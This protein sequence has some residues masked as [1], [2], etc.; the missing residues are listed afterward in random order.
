VRTFV[1]HTLQTKVTGYWS[2]S[3]PNK[4]VFN[5]RWNCWRVRWDCCR[6]D[7][8]L[9]H[10]HGPATGNARSRQQG[11]AVGQYV[12]SARSTW[13]STLPASRTQHPPGLLQQQELAKAVLLAVIWL[14]VLIHQVERLLCQH[15]ALSIAWR[16]DG[17]QKSGTSSSRRMTCAATDH[18]SFV[19]RRQRH[20]RPW[21]HSL[22]VLPPVVLLGKKIPGHIYGKKRGKLYG[23]KNCIVPPYILYA[24]HRWGCLIM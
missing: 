16:R 20:K 6:L 19:G 22:N 17:A 14:V 5:A 21:P 12:D 15:L 2:L 8:R 10:S 3:Q 4:Y 13:S 18:L 11:W 9:S 24:R 23:I 1:Q 7:G